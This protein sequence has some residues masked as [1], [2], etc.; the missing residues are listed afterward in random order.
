MLCKIENRNES[1]FLD[2]NARISP[3]RQRT[4]YINFGILGTKCTFL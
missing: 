4:R 3:G 2:R 1:L